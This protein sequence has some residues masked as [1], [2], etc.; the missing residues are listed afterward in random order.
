TRYPLLIEKILKHTILNH[1]GYRYIQQAYGCTRQLNEQINKQIC[2]QENSLRL[3][4][5]QQHVILNTD[6]NSTDRYVFDELIKFNSISRFHKQRQLLLHGFLMKLLLLADIIVANEIP[7][8]QLSFSIIMKM[9]EKPLILKSQHTNIHTLWVRA[10][11]NALEEYQVTEKL[12]L[13]DKSLLTV[14]NH[15]HNSQAAVAHLVLV[16]LEAHDLISPTTT[17][18]RHR[19]L[20]PYCEITVGSLTLKTPFMKR[21]NNP[22][23]NTSIQFSL[24]DV[25]KDIIHINIFDNEFFSLNENIGYTSIHLIDILPCSLDIFLTQ[26]LQPFTQTIYLNNG[27]SVIMKCTIQFLL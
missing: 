18:E 26:P 21:T 1:P 14:T 12:I 10:I 2:E 16:V 19:S 20:N 17:V 7:N 8:D 4:W 22:K 25:A 5:L 23:W 6:E 13:T 15:E 11:N 9:N 27:A 24:Y 3:D